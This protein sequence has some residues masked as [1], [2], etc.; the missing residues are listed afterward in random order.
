MFAHGVSKLELDDRLLEEMEQYLKPYLQLTGKMKRE[1]PHILLEVHCTL[2]DKT[3]WKRRNSLL[4]KGTQKGCDCQYAGRWY[5]DKRIRVLRD[6]Y[7]AITQRCTPGQE[8]SKNYGDRGVEMRFKS[9]DSF[10]SWVLT[11]LPMEDYT[12]LQF[13][14]IDTQGHY[15]P[16]NLRLVSAKRNA[17]NKR[18][19][20]YVQYMGQNVLQAHLWDLVKTDNPDFQLTKWGLIRRLQ[21]G[22]SV[23]EAITKP[24]KRQQP[25]MTSL[26]PDPDI[27]SLYRE[28]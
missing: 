1:R 8:R 25:Y 21:K 26:M 20:V 2:C 14:R 27:V 13:D 9:M 15:E 11:N 12:G 18:N 10:I 4:H 16:G 23:Q 7:H 28:S 17:M 22:M 24:P 6:R 5:R 19:N 3:F